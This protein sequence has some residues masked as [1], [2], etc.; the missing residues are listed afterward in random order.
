MLAHADGGNVSLVMWK[1]RAEPAYGFAV[2]PRSARRG[3]S[4]K[5]WQ[6]RSLTLSARCAAALTLP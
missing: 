1:A 6:V 5:G 4:R 2:C 3:A